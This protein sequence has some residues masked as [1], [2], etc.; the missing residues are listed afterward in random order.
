MLQ[1]V[2]AQKGLMLIDLLVRNAITYSFVNIPPPTFLAS[3][4]IYFGRSNRLENARRSVGT[5]D[6]RTRARRA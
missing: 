5:S 1:F 4:E 2:R 6:K 3:A